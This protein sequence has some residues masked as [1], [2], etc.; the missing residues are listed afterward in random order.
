MRKISILCVN[1]IKVNLDILKISLKPLLKDDCI[2]SCASAEEALIMLNEKPYDLIISDMV[3]PG[4]N[5]IEFLERIKQKRVNSEFI[6]VTANSSVETVIQAMKK[7][8]LDYIEKP[9]NTKL[10]V[11]K[12]ESLRQKL[13]LLDA[14]SEREA[15]LKTLEE[16]AEATISSLLQKIAKYEDAFLSIDKIIKEFEQSRDKTFSD[17]SKVLNT[18]KD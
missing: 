2:E 17:L 7:G 10:L 15:G 5:G 4:M 11:E 18:I 6:I 8:A 9:I 12:I 14:A 1:D 3:M 16:N 13:A